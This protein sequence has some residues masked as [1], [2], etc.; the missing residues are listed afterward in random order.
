ME[1]A[2]KYIAD[3]VIRKKP[4]IVRLIVSSNTAMYLK[5]YMVMK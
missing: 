5:H 1:R 3:K 2:S 4:H